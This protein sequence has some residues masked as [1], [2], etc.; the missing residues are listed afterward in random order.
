MRL[1]N[2]RI[3]ITGG[4]SGIGL[5][6]VRQLYEDNEL[7]LLARPSG[8]LDKLRKCLPRIAVTRQT[9]PMEIRWRPAS[10]RSL[11]DMITSTD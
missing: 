4:A 10:K 9:S 3:I 2:K 7:I 11:G 5:E 8:D 1:A 6:L